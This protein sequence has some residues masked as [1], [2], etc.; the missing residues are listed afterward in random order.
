MKDTLILI[1]EEILKHPFRTSRG[2]IMLKYDPKVVLDEQNFS[3][4]EGVTTRD[5]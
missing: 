4:G 5:T 2:Y 1:R 3:L